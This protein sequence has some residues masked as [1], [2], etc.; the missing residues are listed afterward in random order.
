MGLVT[1]KIRVNKTLGT[2][3]L[4]IGNWFSRKPEC[5]LTF[6][7]RQRPFSRDFIGNELPLVPRLFQISPPTAAGALRLF[8]AHH[9]IVL[10]THT[11]MEELNWFYCSQNGISVRSIRLFRILLVTR[12]AILSEYVV[13]LVLSGDRAYRFVKVIFEN[14]SFFLHL[15]LL[16]SIYLYCL[17]RLVKIIHFM[18]NVIGNKWFWL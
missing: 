3:F 8:I 7:N 12:C 18:C 17:H 5:A 1:W 9:Y 2:I 14:Y 13:F 15:G 16:I 10:W 11:L 4:S 6:I